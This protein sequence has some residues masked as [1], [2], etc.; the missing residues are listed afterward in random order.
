MFWQVVHPTSA[1]FPTCEPPSTPRLSPSLPL[2]QTASYLLLRFLR[3]AVGLAAVTWALL[4][5]SLPP[6][7][8]LAVQSA[9]RVGAGW[10]CRQRAA[11]GKAVCA[12]APSAPSAAA[13]PRSSPTQALPPTPT[14]TPAAYSMYMIL[15]IFSDVA[16]AV[17]SYTLNLP[18]APHFTN[19][20]AHRSGS[21]VA[22]AAPA[23]A[24]R[25]CPCPS[26]APC[27]D[28]RAA[29]QL[30][31]TLLC[32]RRRR[33]K[34]LQRA[35]DQ[36]LEHGERGSI[37]AAAVQPT[38]PRPFFRCNPSPPL[39]APAYGPMHRGTLAS[40]T[41]HFLHADRQLPAADH[42]LRSAHGR[43]PGALPRRAGAALL[44]RPTHAGRAGL[45]PRVG[46]APRNAVLVRLPG[47]GCWAV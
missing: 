30:N 17:V 7:P 9:R 29:S 6:I 32:L 27:Y 36:A 47:V 2:Q 19:P 26:A 12:V 3:K 31:G 42:G 39:P 4:N 24:K 5:L 28:C 8:E 37:M 15:S 23:G 21:S 46:P 13:P 38:R 1:C 14:P 34:D 18:V 33:L 44:A 43:P 16:A 25:S 22:A 20:C 11:A 10:E 40:C 41:L 35:V 45:L